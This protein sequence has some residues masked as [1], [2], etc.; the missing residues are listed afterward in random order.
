M[1]VK[2]PRRVKDHI[3]SVSQGNTAKAQ[4]LLRTYAMERFL[5]E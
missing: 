5:K 1:T 4:L 2:N 3:R